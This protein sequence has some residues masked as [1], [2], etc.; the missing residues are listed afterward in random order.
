MLCFVICLQIWNY[1][2]QNRSGYLGRPEFYN[3]LKLVTVAQ[4]KRDL[5]PEIVKAALYGPASAKIPAPQI[6]FAASPVSQSNSV[7]PASTSHSV[8]VAPSP[9]QNFGPRGPQVPPST[10]VNQQH[11][12]H[13]GSQL[14]RPVAPV[15]V[16][17]SHSMHGVGNQ[18]FPVGSSIAGVQ[19]PSSSVKNDLVGGQMI[20]KSAGAASLAPSSG[21][22]P[23]TSQAGFAPPATGST[24]TLPP[25]PPAASKMMPNMPQAKDPK[26][27]GFSA[28]GVASNSNF[29]GDAF[30]ATPSHPKQDSSVGNIPVSSASASVSAGNGYSVRPGSFDSSQAT[31]RAVRPPTPQPNLI[32]KSSQQGS[33]PSTSGFTSPVVSVGAGNS[34]PGQ[35]QQPWPKLTQPAI[36]KY[37]K[38]FVAVDTDKDGKITGEQARN[39]FLSWRLPRGQKLFS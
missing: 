2:D 1:A 6:N 22:N 35:P 32:A 25:R 33:I 4:S 36:Q 21:I 38:V 14:V 30:S 27:L 10:N 39:L 9:V 11:V 15:S 5:T 37:T 12:T 34:A 28:N 29:G 8:A 18:G 26:G 24:T 31:Q 20:G 13:Q 23:P 7:A 3:A 16:P 17:A 19:P